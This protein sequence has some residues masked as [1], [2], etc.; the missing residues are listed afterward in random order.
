[1]NIKLRFK[2]LV[3]FLLFSCA[4]F[5]QDVNLYEQFNGR[6]DFIFI[7]NTMNNSENNLN[8]LCNITGASSSANLT[9]SS[10]DEIQKA[11]LYW[12][13]AGTGDFEVNLNGTIINSERNFPLFQNNFDYFCAFADVT[14]LVLTSGNGNYTLSDLDVTPFLNATAYCNNRTNFAGWAIVIVYKNNSLPLNQLNIYDGLQG[15]SQTQQNLTLTLN[16][17]NVID[18]IGAKIGFVAWEG[19]KNLAVNE[20]LRFNGNVLSNSLNPANN[21]FNG[22]NSFTGSTTLYNMDLDVYDIQNYLQIGMPTAEIQLTSGQDFVMISTVVT[23]L[24]S[25][26]PDAT[27]SIDNFS[28]ECNSREINVDYTVYNL[29]STNPLPAG[30]PI[31]IYANGQ[32]IDTAETSVILNLEESVSSSIFITIPDDIPNDFTLEFV[33]DDI[34][35]GTGIVT[36]INESN[37]TFSVEISLPVSPEFNPLNNL[38]SCNQGLKKGTFNFSDYE[39]AVKVDLDCVVHFYESDLDASADTN[40][41]LNPQNY[42][43]TSTP[44]QIFVRIANENC[45]SI[46]SF[47]LE[48]KN[49]PP[50]PYN[51]VTANDDGYND[52]LFFDGLKDVFLNFKLYIYSRWGRLIWEG[53]NSSE[54][55]FGQTS[56]GAEFHIGDAPDGTYFYILDLNDPDYPNPLTGYVYL[57][58]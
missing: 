21:A 32:L 5:A 52:Y 46:A 58:R 23:K 37:N 30:T 55:W 6:F 26:L 40:P 49:C 48:T 11:Y 42:T 22:T 3:F 9:L 1:V 43:A 34:G 35:D 12:A 28:L 38:L 8:T 53:D 24:N 56:K 36:E 20:T 2:N 13:G 14:D 41:I 50:T 16:S 45:Y 19:D 29:N 7:G 18:N 33:V 44:K 4:A 17:L 47:F 15:V 54:N 25:Q 10:S 51:A 31:S 27:I 57:T 39:E